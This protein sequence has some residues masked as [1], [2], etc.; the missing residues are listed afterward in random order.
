MNNAS[1][2]SVLL[3]KS[4]LE[5]VRG[6][7][8]SISTRIKEIDSGYFIVFNRKSCRHEVHSTAN[9]GWDTYCF[10]VPYDRLD[11]RTLEYCR[12]TNIRIRGDIVHAEV[13]RRNAQIA[14]EKKKDFQR[15]LH[16]GS[17]ETADMAAFGI[18]QDELYEG[19]S[20]THYMGSTKSIAGKKGAI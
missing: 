10:T 14:A 16:D 6:D 18:N 7:L 2:D 11:V 9:R 1:I 15:N 13:E 5:L 3:R 12:K 19:Y 20:K 4:Y 17:L 8:Y